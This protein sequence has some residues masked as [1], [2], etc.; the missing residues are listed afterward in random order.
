MGDMVNA[1]ICGT[2]GSLFVYGVDSLS[3]PDDTASAPV[4]DSVFSA[5]APERD[6]P[7]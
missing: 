4:A 6:E 3:E 5:V 7:C 2:T 1:K